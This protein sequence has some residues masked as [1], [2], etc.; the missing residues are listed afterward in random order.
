MP[1]KQIWVFSFLAV[2]VFAFSFA[3]TGCGIFSQPQETKPFFT[4]PL[5]KIS[6]TASADFTV[7]LADEANLLEPDVF[8]PGTQVYMGY[9]SYYP[10]RASLIRVI[11][12][13]N[14][15][16]GAGR[17]IWD[18]GVSTS[19][20]G[21]FPSY[22]RMNDEFWYER[23]N[24]VEGTV[25]LTIEGVTYTYTDPYPVTFAQADTIWGQYSQRYAEMAS[26]IR[27]HT[28]I[29]P[30]ALCFVQNARS[31]RIFYSYE[32]PILVSLEAAGDVRV[33]FALTS[34]ADW[35]N[36][37]DWIEGT[38]NAPVPVTP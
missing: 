7:R 16:A 14:S 5:V 2:L 36:P 33:F 25:A 4:D 10:N 38:G 28:G 21:Q 23:A 34:E 9:W 37:A 11:D 15:A 27:S 1:K 22:I 31:N 13:I 29:T 8:S 35:T 32:L 3:N 18:E 30:E 19:A 26:R 20:S 6:Q 17:A 24:A 12:S